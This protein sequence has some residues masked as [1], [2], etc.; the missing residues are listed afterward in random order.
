MKFKFK[1]NLALLTGAVLFYTACRNS[2]EPVP[3]V[4]VVTVPIEQI[5]SAQ[6]AR[7]ITQTLSGTFG[8]INISEG[9]IIPN[10]A[11]FHN[12]KPSINGNLISLCSFF[13]DTVISA[14]VNIGDTI[15]SQTGGL[16]KFFFSCDT[17]IGPRING[18]SPFNLLHGY[19]AYDSLYTTGVAPGK[20]FIHDMQAFYTAKAQDTIGIP[21]VIN[22]S[23]NRLITF[24]G[25]VKSFIDTTD[26]KQKTKSTSIHSYYTLSGVTVDLSKYGDIADGT[27]SFASTG[28]FH[29]TNWY[30]TGTIQFLGNHMANVII[31]SKTYLVDLVNG[32]VSS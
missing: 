14:N 6:I 13:P 25:T 23:A 19:N 21:L 7:N 1:V 3:V 30:Y 9:L 28:V 10:F 18:Y 16:F 29:S 27:I 20:S 31:N 26:N 8:G 5:A 2:N 32:K 17:L 11:Y 22:G 24:T 15:K 12:N 4:P